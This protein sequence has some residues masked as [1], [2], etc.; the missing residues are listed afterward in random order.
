M[1]Y[2]N[3]PGKF[4]PQR[5]M[6]Q[7]R[8]SMRREVGRSRV[9]KPPAKQYRKPIGKNEEQKTVILDVEK[10][11]REME[12]VFNFILKVAAGKHLSSLTVTVT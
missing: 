2:R 4:P 8:A 1:V 10:D 11:Y 6:N 5:I 3:E 9:C 7:F 12:K